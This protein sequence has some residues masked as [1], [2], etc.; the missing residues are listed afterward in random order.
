[1]SGERYLVKYTLHRVFSESEQH[2]G[3]EMSRY[4]LIELLKS[5]MVTLWSAELVNK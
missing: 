2:D 5:G 1:M 4:E 3:E